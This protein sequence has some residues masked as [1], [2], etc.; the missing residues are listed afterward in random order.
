[1]NEQLDKLIHHISMRYERDYEKDN[2]LSRERERVKIWKNTIKSV[3]IDS[4]L[5]FV[6]KEERFYPRLSRGEDLNQKQLTTI[7]P[8]IGKHTSYQLAS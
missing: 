2:F 1:M 4:L 3:K 5:L 7:G 6:V 8:H